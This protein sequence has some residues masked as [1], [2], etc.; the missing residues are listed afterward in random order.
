MDYEKLIPEL[1]TFLEGKPASLEVWLANIGRYD[2]AIGY[3]WLFWPP[4]IEHDGCVF[5]GEEVADTYAQWKAKYGN[6]RQAM[7]AVINHQHIL[8]LFPIAPEPNQALV[9]Y[10]GNLLKEMWAA[11]LRL[12]FPGRLF[13]VDFPQEFDLAVDNPDITF[14]EKHNEV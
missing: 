5:L 8:D 6:D 3:A 11:K 7:E 9:A 10:L 12:D 1:A 13:V 4:F 2:H 14:W